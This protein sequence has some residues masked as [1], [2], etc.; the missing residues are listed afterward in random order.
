MLGNAQEDPSQQRCISLAGTYRSV[1]DRPFCHGEEAAAG[2][3]RFSRTFAGRPALKPWRTK[4]RL[5]RFLKTLRRS[6]F[7]KCGGKERIDDLLSLD[8]G[9]LDDRIP[10][11]DLGPVEGGESG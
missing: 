11:L 4:G 8:A 3:G 5:T 1:Q 10:L 2:C 7:R 6:I 9:R